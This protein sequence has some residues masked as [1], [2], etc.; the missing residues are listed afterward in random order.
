MEREFSLKGFEFMHQQLLSAMK[1]RNK[2]GLPFL[3]FKS[4]TEELYSYYANYNN[5]I[6]VLLFHGNIDE[7][8]DFF[9]P[10]KELTEE[11]VFTS[12]LNVAEFS[13]AN[14]LGQYEVS[15]KSD[16][17]IVHNNHSGF[18]MK[19]NANEPFMVYLIK[20][21]KQA[22]EAFKHLIEEG[23]GNVLNPDEVV[24]WARSGF[25]VEQRQIFKDIYAHR[26]MQRELKHHYL[27][28]KSMEF[29]ALTIQDL[30]NNGSSVTEGA[31]STDKM[32]MA[33]TIRKI[34]VEDLSDRITIEEI[35][36]K[37]G[38]S[39]T[40]VKSTFK[41]VFGDSI[42]HY[43]QER[44]LEEAKVLLR[45][46]EFTVSEIAFKLGFATPSN[47]TKFFRQKYG[48]SPKKMFIAE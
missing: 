17:F 46:G 20:L 47:F 40:L 38:A 1:A 27:N 29:L 6:E 35:S 4:S 32:R 44:R 25:S 39:T 48:V 33:N 37:V 18:R 30:K 16:G 15:R 45:S 8:L 14:E 34:L 21:R 23:I 24:L 41:K 11:L 43:A 22:L 19:F 26:D 2:K 31:I 42:H 36:E 9:R 13:K 3:D 5:G 28:A 12:Y 7:N 10:Q